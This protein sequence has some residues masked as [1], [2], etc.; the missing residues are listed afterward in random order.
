MQN[1]TGNGWEGENYNDNLD[2]TEIAKILRGKLKE[3]FPQCK[4]SVR[5]ERYAGGQSLSVH[6]MEAPFDVFPESVP[7]ITGPIHPI[8]RETLK[9][10]L[11]YSQRKQYLQVNHYQFREFTG[12]NNGTP[13]TL[14][15]HECLKKV[16]KLVES[17]NY[18]DSDSQIDYFNTNFYLHLNVG[19]WDKPFQCVA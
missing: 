13:I 2:I 11:D 18:D 5:I 15:A 16:S 12:L 7:E 10:R 19:K 9:D 4:F 3:S 6:L 17:F 1:Y 8:E 14:E